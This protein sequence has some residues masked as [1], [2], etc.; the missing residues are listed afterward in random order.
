MVSCLHFPKVM[1]G[2]FLGRISFSRTI[3]E[4]GLPGKS[5][6]SVFPLPFSYLLFPSVFIFTVLLYSDKRFSSSSDIFYRPFYVCLSPS[7]FLFDG[8]LFSGSLCLSVIF[9]LS[10][11]PLFVV[12][13]F[14]ILL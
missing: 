2:L 6:L 3:F 8:V 1:Y 5:F 11:T 13:R 7:G 9:L 10:L 14:G 12:F 4:L